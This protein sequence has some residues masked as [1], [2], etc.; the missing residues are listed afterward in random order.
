MLFR[1]TMFEILSRTDVAKVIV[2][3]S[4]VTAKAKPEYVLRTAEQIEA[5]KAEKAAAQAAP[6]SSQV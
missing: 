6:Q 1:S 4:V 3:E 2:T 5:L